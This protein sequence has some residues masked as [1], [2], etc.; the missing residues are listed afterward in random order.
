MGALSALKPPAPEADVVWLSP[1]D[2]CKMLPGMTEDILTGRR[3]R[4]LDPAF[5]KPTG[6]SGN[7]VLYDR[8]DVIAWVKGSRV[9]T[10][11]EAVA[12]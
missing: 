6:A 9:A 4:R 2:V 3:K 7:V 5:Y 12:S 8:A 11:P 10:H 1:A